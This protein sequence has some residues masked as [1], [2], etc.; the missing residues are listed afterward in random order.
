MHVCCRVG[1]CGMG[2]AAAAPAPEPAAAATVWAEAASAPAPTA[3][4]AVT[5]AA[6]VDLPLPAAV[7]RAPECPAPAD[8]M[9]APPVNSCPLP[10]IKASDKAFPAIPQ[11]LLEAAAQG[12]KT[13]VAAVPTILAGAAVTLDAGQ[14][15][16][17]ERD[18]GL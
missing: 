1:M 17:A 2:A 16:D 11:S 13:G 14:P 15:T 3:P 10:L 4:A 18:R 6:G 8:V 7:L 5:R 12:G 9:P